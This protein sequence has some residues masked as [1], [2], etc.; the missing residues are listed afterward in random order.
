MDHW[1][2]QLTE[3]YRFLENTANHDFGIQQSTGERI[4]DI[5]LP[6]WAKGD[7]LLF[8]ALH[9]KVCQSLFGALGLSN[10]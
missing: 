7:P 6:P 9:R 8:I 2:Y 5:K 1:C 3:Q 4:H 10:Q